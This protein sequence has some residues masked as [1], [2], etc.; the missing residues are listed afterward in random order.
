[1]IFFLAGTSDLQTDLLSELLRQR[2]DTEGPLRAADQPADAVAADSPRIF[3]LRPCVP[4]A[5]SE[6][7]YYPGLRP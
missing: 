5:V 4:A 2:L 1:M 3:R 7:V 6:L